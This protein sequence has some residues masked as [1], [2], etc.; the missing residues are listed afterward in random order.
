MLGLCL[1]KCW[2]AERKQR[3]TYQQ[4]KRRSLCTDQGAAAL[5]E[6]EE[7]TKNLIFPSQEIVE[8]EPCARNAIQKCQPCPSRSRSILLSDHVA[9]TG[10]CL[11]LRSW[12]KAS[13][14]EMMSRQKDRAYFKIKFVVLGDINAMEVITVTL[15]VAMKTRRKR[16]LLHITQPLSIK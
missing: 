6:S 16:R 8:T 11:L 2:T 13:S 14:I 12:Q 7:S 15:L 10:Y 1:K 4:F 5:I 9:R 3:P